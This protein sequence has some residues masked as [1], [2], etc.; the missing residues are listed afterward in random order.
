MLD[1][2]FAVIWTTTPWTLP[3]NKGIAVH[4]NMKYCIVKPGALLADAPSGSVLRNQEYYI[5]AQSR[6]DHV[7]KNLGLALSVV[8]DSISGAEFAGAT[9]TNP[10]HGLVDPLPSVLAADYVTEDSGTGLVHMAPGHGMDD[11]NLCMKH[12]IQAVA[13]VDDSGRF[14]REA[15]P[16]NPGYLEGKLVQQEGIVAVLDFLRDQNAAL[17]NTAPNDATKSHDYVLAVHKIRH[18]YPIDWRT[19]KPVIIRATEQWFANIDNIKTPALEALKNVEFVPQGGRSRLESFVAGRSQWCI[20]RQRAWGVPIPALYRVEPANEHQRKQGIERV[21]KEALMTVKSIEHIMKVI[22]ERGIDA[23]WSDPEDDPSWV[24]PG[25]EGSY[26]RGKD[27]MDVWFDSGTSWTLL[28]DRGDKQ[29]ADVYLEGSDQ[30]RGWFQSSLLT[31]IASQTPTSGDTLEHS[32]SAARPKAPFKTLITHGF[33]LDEN[34]RKM[35]KSLGNTI[36]P[37]EIMNGTL[38]PPLKFNKKQKGKQKTSKDADPNKVMY[39][40][41]GP[42]VLRLWV[43][44]SDYTSDVVIGQSVLQTIN[45]ALQKY[46]VKFKRLIGV[47][48]DHNPKDS[49]STPY[50]FGD[51]IALH[52]LSQTAAL[53]RSHYASFTPYHAV[54]AINRYVNANLSSFYFESL[55]DRLYTGDAVDRHAAQLV[56]HKIFDELCMMLAPATPVLLEEVWDFVPTWM[57]E[58][59]EHPARR[60]WTPFSFSPDGG[61]RLLDQKIELMMK[62][63]DKVKAAQEKAREQKLIGSG[64]EADVVVSLDAMEP[65]PRF[66][67]EL[68]D[69]KMEKELSNL[70]VVSACH[71]KNDVSNGAAADAENVG[72]E[73]AVSSEDKSGRKTWAFEEPWEVVVDGQMVTGRVTVKPA[74]GGKC[75]RCWRYLTQDGEELCQRCDSVVKGL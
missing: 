69:R 66:A 16:S 6:L 13:P 33:T 51:E 67:Q 57:K 36:S 9:Y 11:Y 39:D 8:V 45:T 18:K 26:I 22:S 61:A 74:E 75:A 54:G 34:G 70:F 28:D 25:L 12:G 1:N 63:F 2:L 31:Y 5:V 7:E 30:H 65:T 44:S 14:T 47:L 35:S 10:I 62:V 41:M 37:D 60:V 68:F 52:Q 40:A 58:S 73:A 23:W 48:D 64:L 38:L 50:R 29:L 17:Q 21:V 3:A 19:K 24:L 43:A 20:S 32:N 53:V 46:R 4:A 27:T 49:S 59:Q 42:D 72:D 55:K 15:M 56:A 71:F